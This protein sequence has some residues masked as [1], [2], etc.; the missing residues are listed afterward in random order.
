M[1]VCNPAYPRYPPYRLPQGETVA[2]VG[3][4]LALNEDARRL[5][6]QADIESTPLPTQTTSRSK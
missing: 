3:E 5:T 1:E 2:V 6:L 4:V